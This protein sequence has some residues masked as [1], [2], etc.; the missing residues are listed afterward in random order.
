MVCD[1]CVTLCAQYNALKNPMTLGYYMFNTS[2]KHPTQPNPTQ[3][4]GLARMVARIR[5]V[6]GAAVCSVRRDSNLGACSGQRIRRKREEDAERECNNGL[7]CTWGQR[8]Q[9]GGLHCDEELWRK[10]GR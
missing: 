10:A 9:D 3:T 8:W 2:S 6:E 1:M 4:K 5:F 7:L